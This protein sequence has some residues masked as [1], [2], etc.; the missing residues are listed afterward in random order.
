MAAA[1]AAATAAATAAGVCAEMRLHR[2]EMRAA[3]TDELHRTEMRAAAACSGRG[4]TSSLT[5]YLT[6]SCW[7]DSGIDCG[8]CGLNRPGMLNRPDM[9]KIAMTIKTQSM[10]ID[11]SPE[12]AGYTGCQ[13]CLPPPVNL[14]Y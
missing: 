14:Y 10:A 2:T 13:A 8:T 12:L 11:M 9:K 4:K 5:F 6:S 3:A 7:L 1:M